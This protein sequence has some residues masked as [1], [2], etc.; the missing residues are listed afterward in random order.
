M[1]INHPGAM[2]KGFKIAKTGNGNECENEW[3][4]MG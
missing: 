4:G 3:D 1:K 2:F